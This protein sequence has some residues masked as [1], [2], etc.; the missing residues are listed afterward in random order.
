MIPLALFL[1]PAATEFNADTS[2]SSSPTCGTA[3][4]KPAT[5]TRHWSSLG[6]ILVWIRLWVPISS[7]RPPMPV[8]QWKSKS[9][10]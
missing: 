9:E 8:G 10:R 1:R 4:P 3:Q 7:R 6:G 5:A 2:W